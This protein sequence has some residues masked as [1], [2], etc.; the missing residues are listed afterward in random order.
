M[1]ELDPG[2]AHSYNA[3]GYAMADRNQRLQ[4]ALKLITRALEISP[5]DPFIMDSMGWVK[6]RLGDNAAAVDYLQRAYSKRPEA[7]IAAH[8]GEVLWK[9]GQRDEARKIFNEGVTREPRNP[10]LLETTKRLGV[11]L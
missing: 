11:N 9:Q 2:H 7:D 3:L 5:D 1:I 8:L 6:F 4:E 10:T